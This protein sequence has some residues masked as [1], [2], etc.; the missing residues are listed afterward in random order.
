MRDTPGRTQGPAC[1]SPQDEGHLSDGVPPLLG[2]SFLKNFTHTFNGEAGTLV[3]TEVETPETD[4]A[5]AA[6][7]PKGSSRSARTKKDF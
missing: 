7:Q 1:Q 6:P 5:K 3:L 2:Q 4:K